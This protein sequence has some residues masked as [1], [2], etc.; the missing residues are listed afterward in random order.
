MTKQKQTS[1][2][3]LQNLA[4]QALEACPDAIIIAE[5]NDDYPII[6]VNPIFEYLTGYNK[7]EVLGKNCRFLQGKDHEQADLNKI[8]QLLHEKKAGQAILKNYRKDNSF[9][10]NELHLAPIMTADGIVTHF[11]GVMNDITERKTLEAKLIHQATHD[12]LTDLANRSLLMERVTLAIKQAKHSG[13]WLAILYFDLDRFKFINDSLSHKTGDEVLKIVAKRISENIRSTDIIAHLGGDEFIVVLDELINGQDVI[14]IIHK[15]QEALAKQYIVD[16]HKLVLT[17]SIGVSFY[18]RDGEDAETLLKNA[19]IAMYWAKEVGRNNFQF[20][21]P[22]MNLLTKEHLKFETELRLA[23]ERNEFILHYQPIIDLKSGK[24][25]SVEALL[26][27]NHPTLGLVYPGDFILLA[28]EIG[29]MGVIGEWIIRTACRQIKLWQDA[30][31][32]PIRIAV[33]VSEKQFK[34]HNLVAIVRNILDEVRLAPQFLELELSENI[35]IHEADAIIPDLKMLKEMGVSLTIDD[36]GTGYASFGSLKTFP[37]DKIKI[38]KIFIKHLGL[39]K[40]DASIVVAIMAMAKSL[41]LKVV[42]EGVE[43][44]EQLNFL[45]TR[46]C[47]E[48]QGFY[49]SPPVTADLCALL[50]QEGR[51]LNSENNGNNSSQIPLF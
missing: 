11:I 27:W 12:F 17:A 38:D 34:H 19:D 20:Y 5:A 16:N 30:G 43:T 18:P 42:A 33:N 44:V 21:N 22:S 1:E 9:F 29:L 35:V 48:L 4:W 39:R 50:L 41:N 31:L 3:L 24:I 23:L 40:S 25:C 2:S 26:R 36:F 51:I 15:C 46:E 47:D 28:E 49:F 7:S 14:P 6:Y 13:L 8:H 37:V 45:K 32:S 10:W